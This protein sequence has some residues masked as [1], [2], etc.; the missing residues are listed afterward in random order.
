MENTEQT[1]IEKQTNSF[2]LSKMS[3]GYNWKVKIYDDDMNV[4]KTKIKEMDD[5]AKLSWGTAE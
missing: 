5:W 4:I 2:E 3:K 1:P